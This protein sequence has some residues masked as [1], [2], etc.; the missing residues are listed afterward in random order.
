MEEF[1]VSFFA[2]LILYILL[3]LKKQKPWMSIG[4]EN[5]QPSIKHRMK[6]YR[7]QIH[8]RWA[9]VA[10]ST[11]QYT[12][13]CKRLWW[14]TVAAPFT[15]HKAITHFRPAEE[16][17]VPGK[18]FWLSLTTICPLSGSV[19]PLSSVIFS[20]ICLQES[21]WATKVSWA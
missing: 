14:C 7:F 18:I 9:Q 3:Y 15:E 21:K 6:S 10:F 4:K 16:D 19:T 5:Q 8:L 1:Y 20:S 17:Y 13:R 2:Y 12:P 11:I